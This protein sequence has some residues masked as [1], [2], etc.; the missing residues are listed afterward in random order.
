MDRFN[1]DTVDL[2]DLGAVTE[3]TRG[4]PVG[5]IPDALGPKYDGTMGLS[6]D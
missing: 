4:L 3:E 6:N 2:V 5:E 1:E